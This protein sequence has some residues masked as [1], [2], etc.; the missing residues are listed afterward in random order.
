MHV[1]RNLRN[2]EIAYCLKIVAPCDAKTPVKDISDRLRLICI[3]WFIFDLQNV[4]IRKTTWEIILILAVRSL[5]Y[6]VWS[7]KSR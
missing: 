5:L 6:L 1:L 2:I 7:S 3:L 4:N